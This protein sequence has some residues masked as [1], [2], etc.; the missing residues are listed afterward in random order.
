ME[1]RLIDTHC[2]LSFDPL[3]TNVEAVLDR[4]RTAGVDRVVVPAYD[5]ESWNRIAELEH[6]TGVFFAFGI[7]PWCAD[8]GLDLSQLKN[9]LAHPRT[10]AVGEIGLDFKIDVDDAG[11]SRQIELFRRQI[12]LA[13]DLDLPVSLHCR[14]AFDEMLEVVNAFG[15]RLRGVVHAF[16]RG[17]ELMR[18]FLDAGLLLGFGGAVTR[19]R[20]RRPRRSAELAPLDRIVVETDAPSIGCEGVQ[21]DDIEPRHVVRVIEA[22]ADLRNLPVSTLA[23]RTT[24]NA[25]SLFRFSK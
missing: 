1:P 25:R 9:R 2:H 10:V 24:A 18:R 14:A 13:V 16:S 4:A 3:F 12:E 11:R 23:H 8:E 22:M 15:G 7:H 21:P 17:P 6:H 20:A 5:S 19:P